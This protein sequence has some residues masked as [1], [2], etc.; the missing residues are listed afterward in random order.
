M[1]AQDTSAQAP[2]DHLPAKMADLPLITD[3]L[4]SLGLDQ[5]PPGEKPLL[6][7]SLRMARMDGGA[8][9]VFR[10]ADLKKLGPDPRLINVPVD[11]YVDM[12][13]RGPADDP[14]RDEERKGIVFFQQNQVFTAPPEVHRLTKP[15]VAKPFMPKAL[16]DYADWARAAAQE[17]FDRFA[18][19]ENFDFE[20]DFGQGFAFAFWRR[21]FDMAQEESDTLHGLMDGMAA[22]GANASRDRAGLLHYDATTVKYIDL[23]VKVIRRARDNGINPWINWRSEQFAALTS[24]PAGMPTSPEHAMAVDMIDGFHALGIAIGNCAAGLFGDRDVYAQLRQQPDLLGKAVTE[25]LRLFAPVRLISRYTLEDIEYDG[26]VIPARTPIWLYWGAGNRD[27]LFFERPHQFDMLRSE[28]SISFG[29]GV[30][31]CPGR[32]IGRILAM[33][34]LEPLLQEGVTVTLDAPVTWAPGTPV[35]GEMIAEQPRGQIHRA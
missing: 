33:A 30:Q 11:V 4:T 13:F 26:M 25:A 27:P 18:T 28:P 7:S 31:L 16:P 34:A 8:L 5:L 10:H 22:N 20:A 29:G 6:D 24:S 3:V 19:G 21:F 35:C 9:L 23:L 32:N 2:L 12:Y 15:I 14:L 1:L 17:T